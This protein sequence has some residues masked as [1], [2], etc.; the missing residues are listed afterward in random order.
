PIS[1]ILTGLLLVE[2]DDVPAIFDPHLLDLQGGGIV[3][4]DPGWV[5]DPVTTGPGQH[6]VLHLVLRPYPGAQ[7][8]RPAPL[9]LLQGFDRLPADHAP[10]GHDANPA[11][12]ESA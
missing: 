12:A 10:V 7:D 6:L 3:A 1:G 11:D 2:T 9:V 5:D 8:V 4:L